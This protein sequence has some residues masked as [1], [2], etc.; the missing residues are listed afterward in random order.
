MSVGFSLAACNGA[1]SARDHVI[2]QKDTEGGNL[3]E[4]IG[5]SHDL[6]AKEVQLLIG[7][8]MRAAFSGQPSFPV[9]KTVGQVIEEDKKIVA[10]EK[11]KQTAA[12][13]LKA[14]VAGELEQKR[15]VIRKTMTGTIV[16]KAFKPASVDTQTYQDV[17]VMKISFQNT[18]EKPIK[19][20][21]GYFHIVSQLG[22]EIKNINYDG[23]DLKAPIKS[24][25]VETYIVEL[26]FNQFVASDVKFK[27]SSLDNLKVEWTPT[28]VLFADGTKLEA[29]E[30]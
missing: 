14:K 21:K 2:T 9:G 25:Q 19:A 24:G 28:V 1:P 27:E 13:A 20:F 18:S 6:S 5:E 4:A 10:D 7:H 17:S 3:L 22:D 16:Q 8:Q 11:V 23:D 12:D 30:D 26:P 29:L 15:Q